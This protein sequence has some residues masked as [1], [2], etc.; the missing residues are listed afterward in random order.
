MIH[1]GDQYY[2]PIDIFIGE[3]S[4]TPQNTNAVHVKIGNLTKSYP[5]GSLIYNSES[6]CWEYPISQEETYSMKCS[7]KYQCKIVRGDDILLSDLYDT[8][9]DESIFRIEEIEE[10]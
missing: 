6:E 8:T 2:I 7:V 9:I 1:R 5:N 4:V 3:S 10:E